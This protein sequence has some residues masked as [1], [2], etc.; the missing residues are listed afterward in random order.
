MLSVPPFCVLPLI[1]GEVREEGTGPSTP[2]LNALSLYEL[3]ASRPSVL[4]A[5]CGKGLLCND[6]EAVD[7]RAGQAPSAGS[8]AAVAGVTCM[9]GPLAFS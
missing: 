6:G 7:A 3:A 4:L 8:K 1:A 2:R 9:A 5:G